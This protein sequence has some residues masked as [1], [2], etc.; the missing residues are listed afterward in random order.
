MRG[1]FGLESDLESPGRGFSIQSI[2]GLFGLAA[3]GESLSSLQTV[4]GSS[5]CVF[6]TQGARNQQMLHEYC[7]EIR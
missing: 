6:E 3:V 7:Q 5:E 4:V 2:Y 1:L